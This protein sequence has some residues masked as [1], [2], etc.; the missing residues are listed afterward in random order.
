[1]FSEKL[2]I[3]PLFETLDRDGYIF[4]KDRAKVRKGKAQLPQIEARTGGF[5]WPPSGRTSIQLKRSGDI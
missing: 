4:V 1:V 2:V 3:L 5:S